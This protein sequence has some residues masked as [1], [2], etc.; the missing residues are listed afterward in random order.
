VLFVSGYNEDL[1]PLNAPG[2]KSK[3]LVKPFS[4]S[5]LIATVHELLTA[6]D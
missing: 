1:T 6:P 2:R 4:S 3:F 5:T